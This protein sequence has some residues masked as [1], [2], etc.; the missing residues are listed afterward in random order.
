MK[1]LYYIYVSW[2]KEISRN[3]NFY[4]FYK[5]L[6]IFNRKQNE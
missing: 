3:V 5:K 4:E 1:E 6:K 2:N